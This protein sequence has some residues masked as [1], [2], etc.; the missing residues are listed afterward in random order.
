[1]KVTIDCNDNNELEIIIKCKKIDDNI[2]Q[3]VSL[4]EDKPYLIG[5]L[6][7][8]TYQIKIEDYEILSK[9]I[10]YNPFDSDEDG[11]FADLF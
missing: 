3:I 6:N 2:K 1:M 9:E 10:Q 11:D 8:R 7:D 5:K 4:F